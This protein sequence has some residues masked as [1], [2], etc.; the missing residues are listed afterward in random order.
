MLKKGP[1]SPL[2]YMQDSFALAVKNVSPF[3]KYEFA[4][5]EYG[6]FL[7]FSI[8][9]FFANLVKNVNPHFL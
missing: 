1:L 3:V 4:D 2:Y 5:E 7:Y 9:T 6:R 8:N